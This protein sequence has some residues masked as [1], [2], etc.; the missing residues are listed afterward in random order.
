MIYIAAIIATLGFISGFGVCHQIDKAKIISMES[1]IDQQNLEAQ[2]LLV[3]AEKRVDVAQANA[4]NANTNL[5]NA[6]DST[7]NALNA[8]HDA[9]VAVRLFSS[10]SRE[11]C[12]NPVP[13]S[14]STGVPEK[15]TGE[16]ELNE[17]IDRVIKETA[18]IADIAADYA[19]KAHQ[20]AFINNCGITGE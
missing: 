4:I 11:G 20:F 16:A 18:I 13:G 15:P 7:I 3:S 8:Q 12:A 10:G 2:T 19:E 17:E 9:L 14:G 5:E 6:H 1:A